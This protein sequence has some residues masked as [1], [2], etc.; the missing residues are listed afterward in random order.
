MIHDG[1]AI[2]RARFLLL[3]QAVRLRVDRVC[4]SQRK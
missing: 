3:S 1:I 2:Y 4:I